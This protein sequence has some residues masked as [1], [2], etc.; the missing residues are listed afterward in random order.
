MQRVSVLALVAL[1]LGLG[2]C[3]TIMSGGPD[4]IPVVTNPP[5]AAVFV[6]GVHV[7][8]TPT[9][10]TLD[11]SRSHGSIRIEAPGFAPVMIQRH[12][13]INGWFWMNFCLGGLIGIVVDL[14]TG[15][16]KGFDDTPISIGMT[17]LAGAPQ[18][19]PPGP[20]A[21]VYPPA[22]GPAPGAPVYPPAPAPG[23]PPAY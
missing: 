6:D 16:V 18:P 10:V 9:T 7:G 11:R 19:Y 14:A 13:E 15:D 1:V 5:G 17:P 2:G 4:V 3:A 23:A 22:P 8:N 21:P 20:G 12:K